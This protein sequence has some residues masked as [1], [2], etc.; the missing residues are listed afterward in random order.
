MSCEGT[1]IG[2][3]L[4]GDKIRKIIDDHFY[5]FSEPFSDYSSIP[6]YVLCNKAS[7][8]YKVLLAHQA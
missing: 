6:T 2:F 1:I 8:Y 5:A 7:K 4:E 3:P